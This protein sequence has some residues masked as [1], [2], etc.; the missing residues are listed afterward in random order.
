MPQ[1]CF[2]LFIYF[3]YTTV[4]RRMLFCNFKDMA[5]SFCRIILNAA[6]RLYPFITPRKTSR[7]QTVHWL[8]AQFCVCM[9]LDSRD[10][11]LN[12]L[13]FCRNDQRKLK[14]KRRT[15][16]ASLLRNPLTMNKMRSLAS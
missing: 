4:E 1:H 3:Y 16:G 10:K 6:F 11:S 5:G 12:M 13:K 14:N 7:G 8:G 2:F 9:F 15:K